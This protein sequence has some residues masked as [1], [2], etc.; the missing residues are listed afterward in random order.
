MVK[1]RYPHWEPITESTGELSL[2]A[3]VALLAQPLVASLCF[4][5]GMKFSAQEPGC[6]GRSL[7]LWA[8]TAVCH[9]LC[10]SCLSHRET[11]CLRQAARRRLTSVCQMSH[12]S[13]TES[14][15]GRAVRVVEAGCHLR[16]NSRKPVAWDTMSAPICTSL[17]FEVSR[18]LPRPKWNAQSC[19]LQ[20]CS[21]LR[22]NATKDFQAR[23]WPGA[24]C[25]ACCAN[26]VGPSTEERE[27]TRAR[28]GARGVVVPPP[29]KREGHCP[30]P[31]YFFQ[32]MIVTSAMSLSGL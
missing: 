11:S 9:T 1:Q 4:G 7:G 32:P 19:K 28:N 17:S 8:V 15:G 23:A 6:C 14:V 26:L 2:N 27:A 5:P 25:Q 10:H 3:V 24:T 13:V 21:L 20:S 22:P 18:S 30:R 29:P 16:S 31:P 12:L